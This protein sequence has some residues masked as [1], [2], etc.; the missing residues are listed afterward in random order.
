MR[1]QKKNILGSLLLIGL[2]IFL[3]LNNFSFYINVS[4][5]IAMLM[6]GA[7]ATLGFGYYLTNREQWWVLF[8]AAAFLAISGAALGD[9]L[10]P[11]AAEDLSG[12]VFMFGLSTAFWLIFISQRKHWWAGIPAGVLSTVGFVILVDEFTRGADISGNIMLTGLGLTFMMLWVLRRAEKTGWAIWPGAILLGLGLL[13][14]LV[15]PILMVAAF[16]WPLALIGLGIWLIIKQFR[17]PQTVY[18]SASPNGTAYQNGHSQ[19][20]TPPAEREVI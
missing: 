14:P 18:T 19:P 1:H 16:T 15:K 7:L 2:G 12:A 6:F 20:E 10:L 11:A 3:L 4:P 5:I 8:P 17:R 9:T 13:G